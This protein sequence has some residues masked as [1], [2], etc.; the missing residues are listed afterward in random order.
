[1]YDQYFESLGKLKPKKETYGPSA[2]SFLFCQ[3]QTSLA[4]RIWKIVRYYGFLNTASEYYPRGGAHQD[5]ACLRLYHNHTQK[6][7]SLA[8]DR[9]PRAGH[10][11]RYALLAKGFGN[12]SGYFLVGADLPLKDPP[13]L[14]GEGRGGDG[15]NCFATNDTNIHQCKNW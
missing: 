13:P 11:G 5:R 10:Y 2:L 12:G 6:S 14:Q 1:M 4:K 9:S 7:L 8:F 15:L 3:L